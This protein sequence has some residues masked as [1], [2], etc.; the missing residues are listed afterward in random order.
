[1]GLLTF[2]DLYNEELI[3]DDS[4]VGSYQQQWLNKNKFRYSIKDYL[5]FMNSLQETGL[6]GENGYRDL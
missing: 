4:P 5:D 3:L 1:M 2:K 6:C